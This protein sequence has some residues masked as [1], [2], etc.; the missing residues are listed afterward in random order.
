MRGGGAVVCALAYVPR[1][2][3]TVSRSL[4]YRGCRRSGAPRKRDSLPCVAH[5]LYMLLV[6]KA[7]EVYE[8]SGLETEGA[9]ELG[10]EPRVS[11]QGIQAS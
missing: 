3:T 9:L 4:P 11:P 6:T 1:Q 5:R 8:L 7:G 2:R 10:G